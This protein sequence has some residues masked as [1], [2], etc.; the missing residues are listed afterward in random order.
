MTEPHKRPYRHPKDKTASRVKNWHEY[1]QSRRDH[2]DITLR[3]SPDG[4]VTH[5]IYRSL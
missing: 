2:G 1:E 5:S 4:I 3:I